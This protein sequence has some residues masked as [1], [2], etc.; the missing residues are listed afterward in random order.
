MSYHWYD[1]VGNIGI[2]MILSAYAG[3]QMGK[4]RLGSRLYSLLN[5]VGAALILV[6]LYFAFNLSSFLIEIVWLVISV[7]A[8]IRPPKP[9]VSTQ[10]A[11]KNCGHINAANEAA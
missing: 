10:G 2:V 3:L 7:W 6:S 4:M 9:Q 8:L 5:A 1:F 11:C